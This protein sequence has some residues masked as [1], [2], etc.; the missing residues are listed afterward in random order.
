MRQ[1][2]L[3]AGQW[4]FAAILRCVDPDILD[5][6]PRAFIHCWMQQGRKSDTGGIDGGF[7][8]R[9]PVRGCAGH[10]PV[11]FYYA[12]FGVSA[13]LLLLHFPI[14]CLQKAGGSWAQ[15]YSSGSFRVVLERFWEDCVVSACSGL[16]CS[17][18]GASQRRR[19][20]KTV[21]KTAFDMAT[22]F[23]DG[24]SRS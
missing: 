15:G 3:L 18:A 22:S 12:G 19:A 13:L 20:C 21:H 24:R 1:P 6:Y 4:R 16:C 11:L 2:A 23:L 10:L 14:Y 8:C 7:C 9:C 5:T 17:P